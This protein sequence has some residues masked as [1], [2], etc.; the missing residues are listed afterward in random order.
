[1]SVTDYTVAVLDDAINL[2]S[3]LRDHPDGLTLAQITEIAG[4]I[5]N[6]TFRLLHTLEKRQLVCRDDKGLYF[7]GSGLIDLALHAQSRTLLTDVSRTVMD[8]LVVETGESIFLGVISGSDALCTAARE[9]PH[10][11]RLF[12][13]VGRRAPLHSGGVPKVLFAFMPD[14]ERA[15]LIERFAAVSSETGINPEALE[16]RLAQIR[17]DGYAIVVDELDQGAMSVAAPIF[18]QLGQVTAAMSIAGPS[19]RFSADRIA[20]YVELIL[21]AT[22]TISRSLGYEVASR[23]NGSVALPGMF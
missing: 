11:V 17:R 10:S 20:W 9:S 23:P 16:A 19:S 21:D 3:I 1:V 13:Q 14:A 8:R 18:N 2:L 15:A 6:K 5:K 22:N 7:L 12:A 4:I